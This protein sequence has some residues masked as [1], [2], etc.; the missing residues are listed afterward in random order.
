MKAFY[1]LPLLLVLYKVEARAIGYDDQDL[2]PEFSRE[3]PIIDTLGIT[4]HD[5]SALIYHQL[6]KLYALLYLVDDV[7]ITHDRNKDGTISSLPADI[8][9]NNDGQ[10]DLNTLLGKVN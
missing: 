8:D 7:L 1:L 4:A 2:P 3:V 9:T 6:D 5:L 10:P